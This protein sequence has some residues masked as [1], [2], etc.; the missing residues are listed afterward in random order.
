MPATGTR[1]SSSATCG[2]LPRCRRPRCRLG[3]GA[4]TPAVPEPAAPTAPAAPRRHRRRRGRS[5]LRSRSTALVPLAGPATIVRRL[6]GR[7]PLRSRSPRCARRAAALARRRSVAGHRAFARSLRSPAD[8][9]RRRRVRSLSTVAVAAVVCRSV[10]LATAVALGPLRPSARTIA[11]AVPVRLARP[12]VAPARHSS[13]SPARR[14]ATPRAPTR[15]ARPGPRAAPAAQPARRRPPRA[16][17]S[18]GRRRP[19][20]PR[21]VPR[22]GRLAAGGDLAAAPRLRTR[23]RHPAVGLVFL[24]RGDQVTLTHPRGAG[25]AERRRHRLQL[26][27]QHPG[28]TAAGTPTTGCPPPTP[29]C[30]GLPT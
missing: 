11:L 5:T 15:C 30:W 6:A 19:R 16:R 9:A 3:P 14:S 13:R 23:P 4:A 7:R 1:T 2:S 10:A 12:H 18:H 21:P 27:E 24:D 17:S 28:Q 29:G 20:A 8:C 26:G 25:D 22:C